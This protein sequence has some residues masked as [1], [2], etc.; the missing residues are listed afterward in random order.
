MKST[1]KGKKFY[2]SK[3]ILF[4]LCVVSLATYRYINEGHQSFDIEQVALCL[5]ASVNLLLRFTTK[6]ELG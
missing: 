3:T 6:E 4:N 1:R 2:K 5:T